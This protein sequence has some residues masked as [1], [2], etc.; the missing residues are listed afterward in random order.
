LKKLKQM[1]TMQ[2]EKSENSALLDNLVD[3]LNKGNAHVSLDESLR[4]I[5][6]EILGKKPRNLPYSLWQIADHI[7]I[8][9]SDILQFSKNENYQSPKWPEGY[10]PKE[11]KPS[12]EQ[13]WEKCVKQIKKDRK[14][15]ISL[16]KDSAENLFTVFEYG[17][18]Q[19]LLREA[20]VLADH[21]SYHTGEI[22]VLRRL[23]D[24]W[25]K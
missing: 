4:D 1:K 23:L 9:Q 18:G 13:E 19:T 16:L 25:P 15:F 20:L 8:A 21:N 5:P 24:N 7:R 14:D 17:N 22:I 3:L 2:A 12:S 11:T 10:W 6:F